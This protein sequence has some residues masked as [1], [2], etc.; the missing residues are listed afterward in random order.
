MPQRGGEAVG[1]KGRAFRLS[2]HCPVFAR[3]VGAGL[4]RP[5]IPLRLFKVMPAKLH[6]CPVAMPAKAPLTR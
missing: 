6:F 2:S 4:G 3:S 1:G 5:V